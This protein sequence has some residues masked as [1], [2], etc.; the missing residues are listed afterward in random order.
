[1]SR[2]W[3][4]RQEPLDEP[5]RTPR[6][7]GARDHSQRRSPRWTLLAALAA[8]QL[9]ASHAAA[10]LSGD[11][12]IPGDYMTV[13]DA[14][15]DL[16]AVGVGAGGVTFRVAAG[17]VET[18]PAGGI[19]ITA[20]GTADDP[21]VFQKDGAGD[22]PEITASDSLTSGALND[23]VIKI[24]GG[25][26]IT[27]DGFTLRENPANTTTTAGTNNMAEWG[28]ALLYA[29]TTDGAQNNTIQN[30]TISLN[31][32]YQNTFG[33]YSNSTHSPTSILVSA[34]ATTAAG[35]NSGLRIYGNSISNV[36]I[37]IV[38]VGPTAAADHNEG[39]DIGGTSAA[40]GNS[41]TDYGTTGTFSG[42]VNVS[43]TVNGILVR[44]TRNYNVSFNTVQSSDGG[45]TSGTLRGIFVPAFSSAP[46]GTLVSSIN[47]NSISVRSA[48][49]GGAMQGVSVDNT[50]ATATSTL[51]INRNDFHTSGHTVGASGAITFIL[52]AA[53]ALNTNINQNTFTNLS[54][55]TTG[56][57]TLISNSVTRPA[58]A[59]TNV[60][61]NSIVTGFSKTGS[62]GTVFF[63]NSFGST[64]QGTETNTGNDFSNVTIAGGTVSGWRS[65]D[66]F[67][68][69]PSKTITDNTFRNIVNN[70]GS[71]TVLNVAF[72]PVSPA[73]IVSG[74]TIAD[75]TAT[76]A[77][78]GLTS[79]SG[80]QSFAGNLI[81]DLSSSGAVTVS[82]ISITAGV[83]QTIFGN[84]IHGLSGTN[85]GSVVNGILLSTVPTTVH[86]FNNLVGDLQAPVASAAD[87]V[88][89]IAITAASA[90]TTV[91]LS[92]NTVYI[93]ASSSG[94]NFGTSALFHT[95][96]ATSENGALNARNNVLVNLSTP[97]GTGSTVAFRR[98]AATLANYAAA[99]NN[100]LLYAG[101][102]DAARLI[103]FDGTNA[104]EQLA[105]FQAR[106]APRDDASVTEAPPFLSTSGSSADF[107]HVDPDVPT[108]LESGGIP[109]AGITVDFD[110]DTRDASTPDIGADELEG[111]HLE[112]VPPSIAYTP[113]SNT[114]QAGDRQLAVT[115]SDSSG[116]PTAGALQPRIYFSK[117]AGAYASTGCSLQ[118][119]TGFNGTWT[120]T[121]QHAFV[122]GVTEGDQIDYFVIA[123]DTEGN[124]GSNPGP[125]LDATDV[126]TV[127]SPPSSPNLYMIV[128]AFPASV[129]VGAGGTYASLTNPGG[130]FQAMNSAAFTGDV[131][132]E[133]TSD[134]SDETG[135]IALN[136]LAEDG[137]GD[138]SVTIRPSGGAWTVSGTSA[139]SSGLI[140]LNGA[141]RVTI[142]GSQSGGNDRSLTLTNT[143]SAAVVWIRSASAA[144][145]ATD[146]T[147]R[148]CNISGLSPT[149][150][151]VGILA[152]GS[153]F[154]SAADSP[155][156]DNTLENNAITHIGNALFLSGHSGSLDQNWTIVGNQ[157]GSSV[158]A[159]R[160]TFLGMYL[161]NAQNFLISRNTITGVVSSATSSA[162]MSGIH[163]AGILAGGLVERNQI[164]D[165][166][167][168]NPAG[169][170]S[171]GILLA[172]TSTAS[173]VEIVNNFIWDVASAGFDSVAA[174]DNGYGIVATGGGGY[175]IYFNS[176]HLNTNQTLDSSTTAAL[177][178]GVGVTSAGAFDVRNNVFAS[179]QT[180]G[181]RYGVFNVSP[182]AAAVF[183][184]IDYNDYF[185]QH[186]GFQD[187]AQT[188]LADWQAATGQDEDSLEVAPLFVSPSD[189]HLQASSPLRMTGVPIPSVTDDIDGDLRPLLDPDIGADQFV[190]STPTETPT[191]TAT[192]TPT[193]TATETA[194]PT[195]T[196]T[197]T[198][199]AT[200]TATPTATDTATPTAT[201]TATPTAT[202]TA[203]PTATDTA[204]PTATDTATP[205][206]TDTATPTAT[207]PE[208]QDCYQ[209]TFGLSGLQEVP[210]NS[211]PATGTGSVTVDTVANQLH[212]DISFSG[213]QTAEVGAHIHG[214]ADI[215]QNAGILEN[216]P[217]GSPKI[218]TWNY[219]EAREADILA[220]LTYVNI[221]SSDFPGG[222]IRGQIA[223]LLAG[224]PGTPTATP[225][226]APQVTAPSGPWSIFGIALPALLLLLLRRRRRE[227]LQT[228]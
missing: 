67:T 98:S 12:F 72:S 50:T 158:A 219:S 201:D 211:S 182:A 73:T 69:F 124:V 202:D 207:P 87:A 142:D 179:S 165:I 89:G 176:V 62:G 120:C 54:V 45:T 110:G 173:N 8:L 84:K 100:N 149:G 97:N 200:E 143:A 167:Q 63:Y 134:I 159:D 139:D 31:R 199:T 25:D 151:S 64:T 76:G 38:V 42:Y 57:V 222:E 161:S 68:P 155:N 11:Q 99:S 189:L 88:R 166:K 56:N 14:V 59:T 35:S 15:A 77:V 91:N 126:N 178:I 5:T 114:T 102:P 94:A 29:T 20:S 163:L 112:L 44:N 30:C 121:V 174:T 4:A 153:A 146:N 214:F 203:T 66:G 90:S 101:T 223:P 128:A 190:D 227:A 191:A 51:N 215:G 9:T 36:N 169:W 52:Q 221:H 75:V 208:L 104:D 197:A 168:T 34:T 218:G 204:T 107:L 27:I 212:Y 123:Q 145:G 61:G 24:I 81:H 96:S 70:G 48:V 26:F 125:G 71:V 141:D 65:A 46:T 198:P 33:I 80:S 23:A 188:T 74:N 150:I 18:A 60:N 16:N 13:T 10:Q 209:A 162:T 133:I 79:N 160:L 55:N 85:A 21:I 136:Q 210:P 220:G 196:E 184:T 28:V 41:V 95:A 92:F 122:G 106:V 53:P 2:S 177:Y 147:I 164:S 118:S 117:N 135:V 109:V 115:I 105:E 185:A 217:P 228:D 58:G 7:H 113:F 192:A 213:L 186:V 127:N 157:F 47:D 226:A 93:D 144:N 103:Y 43:D 171:N 175:R 22:N 129:T 156:S 108:Q 194:T 17:H 205:T 206:A 170:G 119:G 148:N 32:T 225:T 37:G 224:C 111:I 180:V 172:A 152:G 216:L 131:M 154:G 140:I 187:S 3:K 40:T 39:L 193:P 181:T 6:Q 138:Y 78:V 83:Q 130:L 116:V 49:P 132:V 137:A 183:S 195:A 19:A 86:I 82:G 1:M